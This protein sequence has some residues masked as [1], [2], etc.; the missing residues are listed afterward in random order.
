[1]RIINEKFDGGK[2]FDWGRTS[3][4]YAKY[5]DIY[6]EEFYQKIIDRNLCVNGQKILDIGT[7]TGLLPRN[8]YKFGG[9]WT[10][11][12]IQDNQIK[13]AKILSQNMNINYIVSATEDISFDE[14]SFD[15][16]TACQCFG[17]FDA[18]KTAPV[19]H[20][21]LKDDGRLLILY[22]AW[23]PFEDE[24]AKSSEDLVLKYSPNWSGARETMHAISISEEYEKYFE[25]VNHEEFKAN[26]PFTKISWN[27]RMKACRGVGASLDETQLNRWE[28]EHLELLDKIA[29]NEFDVLHYVAIAEFK[30]LP[31]LR[32]KFCVAKDG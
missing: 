29:P 15:V 18:I 1:M 10:G 30:K 19:L 17:Y 2:A 5:R 13:Q 23:L 21:I 27:G 7:G 14:E 16:I 6:P 3:I 31:L 32:E 26:I 22:M 9:V 28:K 8:M 25:L 12:D 4:E 11:V 20:R 24:I